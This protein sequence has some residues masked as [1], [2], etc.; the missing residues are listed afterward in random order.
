MAKVDDLLKLA[1]DCYAQARATLH[2]STKRHL[3]QMGDEYQKQ[4]D[5]LQHRRAVIQAAFPK[6][7][8]KIG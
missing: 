7:G 5:E 3:V 1:Q 2:L 4:A 6:P 8:G